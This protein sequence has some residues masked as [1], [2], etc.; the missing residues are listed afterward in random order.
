MFRVRQLT[1]RW[2]GSWKPH[3]RKSYWSVPVF[4]DIHL[5]LLLFLNL[6]LFSLSCFLYHYSSCLLFFLLWY[7]LWFF[8]WLFS[9]VFILLSSFDSVHS[10]VHSL[11]IYP[12]INRF[13][14]PS[15]CCCAPCPLHQCIRSANKV[16][17]LCE[18]VWKGRENCVYGK[19]C[20]CVNKQDFCKQ[21]RLTWDIACGL[22][23]FQ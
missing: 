22:F 15:S 20:T 19:F 7:Q 9:S 4:V 23:Q 11:C 2:A 12:W 10:P 5:S 3:H 6:F 13:S 17:I 8:P 18:N 16:I 21:Q 1:N 14:S